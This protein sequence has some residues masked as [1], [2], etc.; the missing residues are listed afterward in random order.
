[1]KF[2]QCTAYLLILLL[3]VSKYACSVQ[4]DQTLKKVRMV[5][6][7]KDELTIFIVQFHE[8]IT[9]WLYVIIYNHMHFHA[10][11]FCC[12]ILCELFR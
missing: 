4:S 7:W 9:G 5:E 12:V 1:M 6:R 2:S 3:A 8:R 10:H 11:S